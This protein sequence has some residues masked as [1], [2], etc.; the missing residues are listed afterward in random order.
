MNHRAAVKDWT[1][2]VVHHLRVPYPLDDCPRCGSI[3]AP[4]DDELTR[5]CSECRL[6]VNP[7]DC[8]WEMPA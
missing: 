3:L 7:S 5:L 1:F 8:T 2:L 6:S 4:P